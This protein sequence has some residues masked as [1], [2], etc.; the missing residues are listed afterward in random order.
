M[1]GYNCRSYATLKS[2]VLALLNEDP[3]AAHE[4][5]IRVKMVAEVMPAAITVGTLL[6]G[7]GFTATSVFNGVKV[8]PT[9]VGTNEVPWWMDNIPCWDDVPA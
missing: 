2:A 3:I 1:F 9:L 7:W 6:I 8:A 4:H 5:F